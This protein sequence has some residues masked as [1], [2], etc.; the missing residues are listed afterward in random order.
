MPFSEAGL[1]EQ[2]TSEYGSKFPEHAARYAVENVKVDWNQQALLAA[3]SYRETLAMSNDAIWDQLV[4]EYGSQFTPE[5][6]DYA[7][8]NLPA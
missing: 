2:L 8:A 4:S 3:I 6:A 5:Q 7:I 1:F